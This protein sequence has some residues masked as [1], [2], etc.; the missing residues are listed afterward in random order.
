MKK[1]IHSF[2]M[3]LSM[4]TIIPPIY[5]KWDDEA[6]KYNLI[7]LPFIGALIGGLW[8]LLY[9]LFTLINLPKLIEILILML[10][11]YV[12]T[13]FI[14][15][16]GYMDVIDATSSY[17]SLEERRSILKD[18]HVGSFAVVGAV[19]AM[20]CH[21]VFFIHFNFN[22]PLMLIFIPITSRIMSSFFVTVLKPMNT[23]SYNE[24]ESKKLKNFKIVYLIILLLIVV[25]LSVF[26]FK[27]YA[28]C[29]VMIIIV[30]SLC[31]LFKYNNLEGMNGDIAGFS[32]TISEIS[33][34]LMMSIL[35][36]LL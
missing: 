15:F 12:I 19:V 28:L 27:V 35:G 1:L 36:A 7:M 23:S 9:Y 20:L 34:I 18:S 10:F 14:H 11:P 33:S 4:F 16:D 25:G 8:C 5:N 24:V 2:F 26:L 3:T 22:Y 17:K 29:I 6:K 31:T 21:Y 30:H 32:L 13:G